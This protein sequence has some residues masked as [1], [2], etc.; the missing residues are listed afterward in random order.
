VHILATSCKV[1][2]CLIFLFPISSRVMHG[3]LRR[4]QNLGFNLVFFSILMS[5]GDEDL[6]SSNMIFGCCSESSDLTRQDL[7]A[8]SAPAVQ[9]Y[10]DEWLD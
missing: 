9:C 8:I 2:I 10:M 1:K 3:E 5:R 7:L 6:C 4:N